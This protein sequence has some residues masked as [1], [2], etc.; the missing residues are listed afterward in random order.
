VAD[1]LE[2][3]ADSFFPDVTR[4]V[5]PI[6]REEWAARWAGIPEWRSLLDKR[7]LHHEIEESI[8]AIHYYLLHNPYRGDQPDG[9]HV[10]VDV[11]AGKGIY[12]FLLSYLRP[13]N[14][15][16]I[17]LLEKAAI[18]WSH[19]EAANATAS[20]DGRP[21]VHIWGDTNL[22]EHDR[23]LARLLGVGRPLAMSGIHLCKQ[24]GPT[25]CGLVNG[26]GDRCFFSCLAP[27]CLPRAIT[28]QGEK[29][30]AK[31]PPK[32]RASQPPSSLMATPGEYNIAIPVEES[33][34]SRQ[35]RLTYM[36]RRQCTIKN[37]RGFY[38]KKLSGPCFLCQDPHHGLVQCSI[39]ASMSEGDRVKILQAEHSASGPCWNCLEVGHYKSDCPV[40]VV[41]SSPLS[42]RVPVIQLD[43]SRVL[44]DSQPFVSYCQLLS[45][46]LG[47]ERH[48]THDDDVGGI[49][50][51]SEIEAMAGKGK[52]DDLVGSGEGKHSSRK[53]W[54]E[55]VDA[56]L[57][58]SSAKHQDE[59]NWNR[60]RKSIFIISGL[61][62]GR[63]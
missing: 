37:Q 19:I 26:L 7:T 1:A 25:F 5:I 60:D 31:K 53:R 17:V 32:K 58:C 24:L 23:V 16:S 48:A 30:M 12:S 62:G 59:R 39:L 57:E 4:R 28:C 50:V 63:Q 44:S 27:C 46:S 20:E 61:E 18:N 52:N 6:L 9:G 56:P 47:A 51:G 8:V 38:L 49:N 2:A 41:R 40:A 43:V 11:C 10:V 45:T 22:H 55:V 54:V 14:V 13:P 35:A 33:P 15:D 21:P 29:R 34:E 36:E 42:H 3:K